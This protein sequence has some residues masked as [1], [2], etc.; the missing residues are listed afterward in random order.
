V[1]V[2]LLAVYLEEC[3]QS[4]N[5]AF[6]SETEERLPEDLRGE[7]VD[8]GSLQQMP[9]NDLTAAHL[10]N[11]RDIGDGYEYRFLCNAECLCEHP[12]ELGNVFQR[13]NHH[14]RVEGSSRERQAIVRWLKRALEKQANINDTGTSP[15]LGCHE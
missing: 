11:H 12:L 1:H 7:E 10:G 15:M 6:A 2:H 5:V 3:T 8:M 13:L 9:R 4:G 14:E